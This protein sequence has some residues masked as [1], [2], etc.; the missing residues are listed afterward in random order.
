MS[1]IPDRS[2]LHKQIELRLHNMIDNGLINEVTE[3][4]AK[5]KSIEMPAM[6]TVG[7]KQVREYLNGSINLADMRR[8]ILAATRQ[9]AKRQV[10]W[11]R[12]LDATTVYSS[13]D[14]DNIKKR[15]KFFLADT[16]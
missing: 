1:I 12:H 2:L 15:V 11:L 3:L 5:Y 9:L 8:N 14:Y 13:S 7:Y 6:S 16:K 10:T 4:L